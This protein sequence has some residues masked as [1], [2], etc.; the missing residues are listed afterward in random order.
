M[1]CHTN[2]GLGFPFCDELDVLRSEFSYLGMVQLNKSRDNH[3]W[4]LSIN[5]ELSVGCNWQ[6]V[7]HSRKRCA[8]P[9]RAA[10]E[11]PGV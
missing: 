8:N 5:K 2:T 1:N 6:A 3:D 10:W 9:W 11:N 7:S 4:K